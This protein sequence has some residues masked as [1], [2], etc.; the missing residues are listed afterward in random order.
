MEV[1]VDSYL[2]KWLLLNFGVA[3]ILIVWWIGREIV[4]YS[5]DKER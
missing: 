4:I 3:A 2:A 5:I 1:T